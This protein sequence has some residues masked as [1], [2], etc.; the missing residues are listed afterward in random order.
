MDWHILRVAPFA[1]VLILSAFQE[2]NMGLDQMKRRDFVILLGAGTAAWSSGALAQPSSLPTIGILGSGSRNGA[3]PYLAAF[4]GGMRELGYVEGRNITVIDLW[5]DRRVGELDMHANELVRRQVKLIVASGGLISAKAAI[6]ATTMIPILFVG[7]FDPVELGLVKSLSKP[8]GNATGATLFSTELL[9][10]QLELLYGLGP[11]IRTVGILLDPRSVTPDI[12]AKQAMAA[13]ELKSFQVRLFNA[14][15][16]NE[17]DSV[18]KTA[19]VEQV[20]AFLVTGSPFFSRR[21][22]QIV[23]LAV[24]YSMPIIYPWRDYVDAGGLMSYGAELTW[25]Y[26]VVGQYAG[27]I[28]KGEKT[29]DLP[30]QQ[31]TRFNLIINLKAAK[32]LGLELAKTAPQL[33]A[34]AD[35]VI[36]E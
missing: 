6:K 1:D 21:R 16:A 3:A 34:L 4:Q 7:G 22:D 32:V 19:A 24:R 28:L 14:S 12:E 8:G 27:R 13:G 25:A 15:I 30:V 29:S 11:R 10:K 5:A 2:H 17:I 35:E 18:F 31:P 33:I 20:S 23:A 26:N 36:E 9:Q